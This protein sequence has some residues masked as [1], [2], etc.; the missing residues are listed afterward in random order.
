[1]NAYEI[2]RRKREGAAL[3]EAEL[4]FLVGG[5]LRGEV[6]DYQMA[7]FLM[8]AAIR[9]M[10]L[11]ETVDLTRVMMDSGRVLDFRGPGGPVIDKHSTGGVGDK[12]SIPLVPIAVECGLRVPMISG[13]SLGSTGGTL[14]KIEAIVGMRT[15]LAPD[16][17]VRQV[18]E[19]GGCFGAQTETLVPADRSLYALRDASATVES[20]PLIV[21]S[22][23][24]KKFA[25][26]IG[27]VVIDVKCGAGAFMRTLAEA[28][29]L[30]SAL[31]GAG[32]AM[33]IP[34]KTVLTAM[35]EPL[36]LAVGNA[37]EVEEAIRILEGRGPS[38]AT[39]LTLRLVAE[40]L[41]L[42]G[43]VS[44][45]GAGAALAKG[46]VSSGRALERFERIVSAQGGRLASGSEAR[47]LPRAK[48]MRP[49]LARSGGFVSRVDARIVGE[50]VREL[51][52]GRFRTDDVIDPAA[53]VILR[54][55]RGDE[56]VRGEP[57]LE[58]YASNEE[59]AL[60]AAR[61][62]EEAVSISAGPV[63]RAPLFLEAA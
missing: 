27:G 25:E 15:D 47:G 21:S 4:R 57:L 38:D 5:Y 11:R 63:S 33:G 39:E 59:R 20:V 13:R 51:G 36:G 44:D 7:A 2:I 9:G 45:A 41:L 42:A 40:M 17:L 56:V 29:E 22:I 32:D 16:A 52:G 34:V 10:T 26:G 49:V 54:K 6:R 43:L 35:D 60:S 31:E 23:L 30:A 8:A 50:T 46:A 24:S 48:L 37:L 19:V 55:K 62:L 18:N 12:I 28:R 61:S 53:G 58:V 14:D 3:E 1:M